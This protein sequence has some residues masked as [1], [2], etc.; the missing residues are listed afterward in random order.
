MW[1]LQMKYSKPSLY[2]VHDENRLNPTPAILGATADTSL[3]G[4]QGVPQLPGQQ[5]LRDSL[6]VIKSP[7][8]WVGV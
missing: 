6:V 7:W 4:D 5:P 1:R 3:C 8:W 2:N